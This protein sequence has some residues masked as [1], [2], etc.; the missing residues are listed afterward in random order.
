MALALPFTHLRNVRGSLVSDFGR[1]A[2]PD[3]AHRTGSR[4]E[5]SASDELK[6][7][8][9]AKV[10]VII[11]IV[12]EKFVE[13]SFSFRCFLRV[14][15]L[16]SLEWF[17]NVAPVQNRSVTVSVRHVIP[18]SGPSRCGR[19]VRGPDQTLLGSS[20]CTNITKMG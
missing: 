13:S 16:D 4:L 14:F 5:R 7:K 9:L 20:F 11:L 8:I 18:E 17:Q 12:I 3:P 2:G 19:I 10:L 1:T 15:F 6:R